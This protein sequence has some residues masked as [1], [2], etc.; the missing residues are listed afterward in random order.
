M[1]LPRTRNDLVQLSK[2]RLPSQLRFDFLRTR[3]QH[4]RISRPPRTL[5]NRDRTPRHAS[6]RIDHFKHCESLTI[7]D[8]VDQPAPLTQCAQREQM[9]IS[10]IEDVYVIPHA[11]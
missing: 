10:Q 9:S 4:S 11:A 8:V 2:L 5:L 6:H 7:A 3:Y 1:P